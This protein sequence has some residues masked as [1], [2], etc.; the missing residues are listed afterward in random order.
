MSRA[1]HRPAAR[2]FTLIELLVVMAII[3]ILVAL[4][5]PAVQQARE[6][7]EK[8]RKDHEWAILRHQAAEA[9]HRRASDAEAQVV[10]ALVADEY[11]RAHRD[12]NDPESREAILLNRIREDVVEVIG[13]IECR[14]ETHD[15]LARDVATWPAEER[16]Q[17]I[18]VGAGKPITTHGQQGFGSWSVQVP[19]MDVAEVLTDA[20]AAAA[21]QK[22]AAAQA[23]QHR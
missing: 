4:L 10:R 3:G 21:E 14:M 1:S 7:V 5:L 6:A 9:A 23:A 17:L 20:I 16:Q 15:R 2:G 22:R 8:P 18:Q 11:V 12:Y 13:L 19:A